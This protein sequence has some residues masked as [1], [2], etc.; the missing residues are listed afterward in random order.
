MIRHNPMNHRFSIIPLRHPISG[1]DE[2]V[3]FCIKCG[4]SYKYIGHGWQKMLIDVAVE[5]CDGPDPQ[6]ELRD[7]HGEGANEKQ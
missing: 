5:P 3:M 1:K 7:M 4:T 2:Q 6:A